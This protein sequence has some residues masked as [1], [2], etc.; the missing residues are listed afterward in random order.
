MV[1]KMEL[2][3]KQP[4]GETKKI[5]SKVAIGKT[6]LADKDISFKDIAEYKILDLTHHNHCQL[7]NSGNGAIFI[8]ISSITGTLLIPDMGAWHGFKQ[9]AKFLN[10]PFINI[11]TN[12]GLIDLKSLKDTIKNLNN[13]KRNGLILTSFAAYTAE[14]NI[15]EIS[16]ICKDYNIVLIEDA[17][18]S[19]GDL[20][21]GL[22]DG[23]LSDIIV[24]STG[25]PKIL[26]VQDGGFISTND[27]SIFTENKILINSFK[28]NEITA[29]GIATE[30]SYA[31]QNLENLI[32][33][34]SYIKS[35]LD[36]VV[37]SDKRGINIILKS[38]NKDLAYT[39]KKELQLDKHSMITKCPN[40]NR[41]KIKGVAIEIK[42]LDY[43]ELNKENLDNIIEI[44][45]KYQ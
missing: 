25:S 23:N 28:S 31:S 30:L 36:N 38:D 6:P 15:S 27:Q 26:N 16:K 9:I 1:F 8:A 29:S 13:E 34:T 37:H 39:L 35:N 18:G 45:S 17:S 11:K 43:S 5:M 33:A 24:C 21:G 4:L 3:F 42:N 12:L 20:Q 19:I 44:I 14:Q 40:Y 7:V 32:K 10:I 2:K 41:L 22:S